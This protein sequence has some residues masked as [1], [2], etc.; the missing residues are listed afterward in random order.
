M[1]CLLSRKLQMRA[2]PAQARVV[3]A[4]V[5]RPT[6]APRVSTESPTSVDPVWLFSTMLAGPLIAAEPALAKEGAFGILEGRSFALIHPIGMGSLLA[7][8]MYAGWLGLQVWSPPRIPTQTI[9]FSQMFAKVMDANSLHM[10][11]SPNCFG[12]SIVAEDVCTET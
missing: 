6:R 1:S 5:A 8:T 10:F 7:L 4:H 3:H 2:R 9:F 11:N 12:G